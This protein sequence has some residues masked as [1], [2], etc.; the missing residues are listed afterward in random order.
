[1]RCFSAM[2]IYKAYKLNLN[3]VPKRKF[4]H[5]Q[6]RHKRCYIN[7]CAFS[8]ELLIIKFFIQI[9]QTVEVAEFILAE[10]VNKLV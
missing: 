4:G 8:L 6:K 1:M 9:T 5:V 2:K 3:N 10:L 7:V